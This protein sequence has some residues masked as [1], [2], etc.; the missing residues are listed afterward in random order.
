M[1]G[2][3]C[4]QYNVQRVDK[5][6]FNKISNQI[7]IDLNDMLKEYSDVKFNL[8]PSYTSKDSFGDLD[9][10]YTSIDTNLNIIKLIKDYFNPIG[11]KNNSNCFSFVYQYNNI[12]FQ[13][14]M[15]K[16]KPE[17]YDFNLQYF[18]YNDLGNLLGIQYKKLGFKLSHRG[19]LYSI[20]RNNE[21]KED[22]IVST[23]WNISLAFL[24]FYN[25]RQE[26]NDLEE[27]F[28]YVT[29][30]LYFHPG[31]YPLEARNHDSRVRDRKRPTYNA[32]LRWLD[33]KNYQIPSYQHDIKNIRKNL[34]NKAVEWFDKE[35]NFDS[36]VKDK[37]KKYETKELIKEKF[38]GDI[39]KE[40]TRLEGKDLGK[41][42]TDFKDSF[43]N[44]DYSFEDY[45]L[46]NS[47]E[48]IKS[49]IKIFAR[50]L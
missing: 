1:G 18:S 34:Y 40:L 24:G 14:D 49:D 6:T 46:A 15:I 4:K 12:N 28:K 5:E 11:Y 26:F 44:L 33:D 22:I 8:I 2:N 35:S 32:F 17:Y 16:S 3:A 36:I 39:V 19:L 41:F 50:D 48:I 10:I 25:S 21:F 13:V 20:W 45:V 38:N 9:I 23:D 29:T 30:G 27:I 37:I 43:K 31:L 42:I 7:T 47:I